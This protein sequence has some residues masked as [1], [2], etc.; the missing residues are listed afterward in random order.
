MSNIV[1]IA[2]SLDGYIADKENNLDWLH[3]L[4]N[5]E[6]SDMGFAEFM[7]TIDALV[8][9][10]NTLDIVL[11]FDIDWPYSKPVYVLSNT[12]T[13]VPQGYEDKVF[14]VKGELKQVI[15]DLNALGL[16][17][18]YIDGGKTVQS[19]LK[20]DLIDEMIITTIPILLGGGIPLFGDLAQPLKFKHVKAERLL[21]C[22]V[23]NHY[24][25]TR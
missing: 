5:P 7:E 15:S 13:Q 14:L 9:G 21:D 1:Y 22:I 18:L 8:M 3:D 23:K 11:G 2:T 6:G 17:N 20:E 24:I 19:F 10:R 4:P 12:M 16:N 25:R